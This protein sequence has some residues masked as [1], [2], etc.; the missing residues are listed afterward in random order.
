MSKVCL[1]C[2]EEDA[3]KL[4]GELCKACIKAGVKIIDNKVVF[5]ETEKPEKKFIKALSGRVAVAISNAYGDITPPKPPEGW[6]LPSALCATSSPA[7][8]APAANCSHRSP[9][10]PAATPPGYSLESSPRL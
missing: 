9:T 7:P 6:A 5:L 4:V 10:P 2:Q 8:S 1:N 3:G